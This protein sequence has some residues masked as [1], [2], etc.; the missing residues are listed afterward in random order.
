MLIE[1]AFLVLGPVALAYSRIQEHEADRFALE[2]THDQP[3]RRHGVRQDAGRE[4]E[5]PPPRAV[6]QDLP[7]EPPEHRRADRLLQHLSPLARRTRTTRKG[8]FTM[9]R[10]DCNRACALLT[11]STSRSCPRRISSTPCGSTGAPLSSLAS[12][13]DS[14]VCVCHPPYTWTIKQVVGHL[15][16]SERVFGYRALR[17]ARGDATPLPGF[18]ENAYANAPL[19]MPYPWAICCRIWKPATLARR[20]L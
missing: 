10:P 3:L 14:E 9:A 12:V 19:S 20:V 2:L 17:F 6:L 7:V 15:I 13:P 4:P 16:D 5:Q 18:D 11:K 8:G 1:V